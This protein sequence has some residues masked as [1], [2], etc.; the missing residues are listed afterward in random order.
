MDIYTVLCL[1]IPVILVVGLGRLH[2]SEARNHR[3]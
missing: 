2:R 1:A 3:L